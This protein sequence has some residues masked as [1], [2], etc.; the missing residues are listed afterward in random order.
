MSQLLTQHKRFREEGCQSN[1][2]ATIA[3]PDV[4][5]LWG[6][7]VA[8]VVL[9]MFSPVNVRGPSWIIQDVV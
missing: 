7:G 9:E 3:T 4:R 8:R 2:K 1:Q 5:K 6:L